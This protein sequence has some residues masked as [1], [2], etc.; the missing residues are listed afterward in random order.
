MRVACSQG[1]LSPSPASHALWPTVTFSC[2][3]SCRARNLPLVALLSSGQSC[4]S[5]A[6]QVGQVAFL[7]LAEASFIIFSFAL[8]CLYALSDAPGSPFTPSSLQTWVMESF[9]EELGR[10]KRDSEPT[11]DSCWVLDRSSDQDGLINYHHGPCSNSR[12]CSRNTSHY[13]TCIDIYQN[14]D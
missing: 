7:Q 2:T 1:S 3:P 13:H 8:P 12:D 5:M 6:S 14:F 11:H 4:P 9:R 10:S